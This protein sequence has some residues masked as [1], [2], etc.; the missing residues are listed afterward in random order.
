MPFRLISLALIAS[1]L[2]WM[3]SLKSETPAPRQPGEYEPQSAIW[4]SA[5]PDNAEFMHVTARLVKSLQPHVP[6]K[7]LLLDDAQVSKARES[8]K[9]DGVDI[10]R[11]TFCKDPGATLFMRDGT[12]FMVGDN[13]QLSVLDLKWSMYGLP[14]WCHKRYSD[15]PKAEAECL[16]YLKPGDDG[17]DDYLS[18][19]TNAS[20]VKSPLMLENATFEVNGKGVLLITEALAHDRQPNQTRQ[21]IE[22]ELLKVPGIK[23]VI[24]LGEGLAEDPLGIATI[25]GK[26]VGRGAGG[27]TDEFVRFVNANT[28]LLAWVDDERAKDH[29]IDRI[30]H[31]RMKRNFEILSKAT[32]QDG[33]PFQVIKVPMPSPVEREVTL[34]PKTDMVSDWNEV[35]FHPSEGRKAG[36]K[37]TVVA[38]ASY[39]NFIIT[40]DYVLV[41]SFV[42]DGTPQAIQDKVRDSM[43]SAF[44]GRTIEFVNATPFTWNGGG[45]H[46][47]TLNEPRH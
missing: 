5:E 10:D 30:N 29:P 44:P 25:E 46:C 27:H 43:I 24:W 35:F 45:P 1:V 3:P 20:V 32:D 16:S 9:A 11:V 38:A 36:D 34:A 40:N 2:G 12:V 14:T 26:Y 15:N 4:L 33:K 13:S 37:V 21:E 7:M 42:E 19:A 23:K 18:H 17:L 41:P 8:L 6:I 28:I 22:N 31:E 39:L 47:A